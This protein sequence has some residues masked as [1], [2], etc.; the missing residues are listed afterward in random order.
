M[1]GMSSEWLA[2]GDLLLTWTNPVG[3]TNWD[4]VTRLQLVL[5][6]SGWHVLY[7]RLNPDRAEVLLPAALLANAAAI[8]NFTTLEWEIQPR[9]YNQEMDYARAYSAGRTSISLQ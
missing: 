4:Q 7:V 1:S 9:M 6:A 2:N 3:E 5:Y 8:A